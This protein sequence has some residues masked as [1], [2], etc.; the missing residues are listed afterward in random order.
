M[1]ILWIVL[2]TLFLVASIVAV[3]NFLLCII[4]SA[5]KPKHPGKVNWS[6]LNNLK[7]NIF[8]QFRQISSQI[9]IFGKQKLRKCTTVIVNYLFSRRNREEHREEHRVNI[10]SSDCH[11]NTNPAHTIEDLQSN[12]LP[13]S[14]F[15]VISHENVLPTLKTWFKIKCVIEIQVACKKATYLITIRWVINV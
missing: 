4:K 10:S 9:L 8:F 13:P 1:N 11:Q 14:Y 5:T 2:L 12:D 6:K 15:E 7:L 3:S